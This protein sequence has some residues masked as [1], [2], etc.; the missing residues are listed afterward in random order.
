[1]TNE[2]YILQHRQDDV[3]Q[4]ALKRGSEGVDVPWCLQ[5]IEGWQLARKKLPKW[6]DMENGMLW[7]PPRLSMEQ[8]SSESTALYKRELVERLLPADER[9][10]MADLTGGFGIDF[11]YMAGSF[12]R[13]VYVERQSHLC[14]IARHNFPLLGLNHAEVREGDSTMEIPNADVLYLDPARRDMV[15]RKTVAIEDCTPNVVEM[16]ADLLSRAR[17]LIIKLSPMLDIAQALR[18]LRGVVEVHVVSVKGE[19]KEL[20][21]VLT[22]DADH[23]MLRFF[24]ANLESADELL[25]CMEEERTNTSARVTDKGLEDMPGCCLFEPNAS[26]LKSGCQDLLCPRYGVEKLHPCSNLFVGSSFLEGFPGRQFRIDAVSDF[27][28]KGLK[29]L[30]LGIE[31]GNLTTRNFPTSVAELRKKLKLREGGEWYFFATTLN[32]GMHILLRCRKL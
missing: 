13:A 8:C 28:K 12:R 17:Y 25:T 6:S 18:A 11:S 9:C 14:D 1:M 15:G 16:Q 23:Q 7:Y 20:L 5:Q 21:L 32:N 27:S 29:A 30:L 10:S 2:A 26:V 24:C 19:C 3:R 4:L 31:S 22:N